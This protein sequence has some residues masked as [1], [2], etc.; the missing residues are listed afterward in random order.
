MIKNKRILKK[1]NLFIRSIIRYQ[2]FLKLIGFGNR[3][4]FWIRK[5][6]RKNN[7]KV[8][9]ETGTYFGDTINELKNDFEKI[10]TIEIDQD[11]YKS[12]RKRFGN[13][14]NIKLYYGDSA[15]LLPKIL[16]KVNQPAIIMLDAHFSGGVTG[17]AEN[18]TPIEKELKFI[19]RYKELSHIVF[20][21]DARKYN[22]K[23]GYPAK[24]QL[25]K[26]LKNTVRYGRIK[27]VDDLLIAL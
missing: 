9:I 16:V 22:G 10:Y 20:I 24:K 17:K 8:L 6:R 21:D 18:N 3:R 15:V 13:S 4:V 27:E 11:L 7:I 1:I 19:K 26:I 12:A 2:T 23:D 14:K 5:F 25:V